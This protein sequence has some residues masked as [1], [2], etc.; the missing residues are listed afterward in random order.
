MPVR[1]RKAFM[2]PS[3]GPRSR[4]PTARQ[5]AEKPKLPKVS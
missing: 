5:A 4:K 2:G 1:I 3:A